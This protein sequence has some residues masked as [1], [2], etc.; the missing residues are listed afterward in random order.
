VFWATAAFVGIP[1]VTYVTKRRSYAR[2]EYRFFRD[3]LEY[4]R[5]SVT[6]QQKAIDYRSVVEVDLRKGPVQRRYGLGTIILATPP[7]E[8][9]NRGRKLGGIH[10]TDVPDPDGLYEE[11]KRLV[12]NAKDRAPR[13]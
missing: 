1:L 6:V 2:T 13:K 3:R 7:T 11:L 5:G 4:F 9:T 8:Y 10:I 12:K